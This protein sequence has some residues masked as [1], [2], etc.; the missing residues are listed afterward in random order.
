MG[1]LRSFRR[2]LNEKNVWVANEVQRKKVEL[3]K[4]FVE[5]KVKT[6]ADFARDVLA[7]VG[8]N[9]PADIKKSAEETI[10]RQVNAVVNLNQ[11]Q[12]LVKD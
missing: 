5:D 2:K 10:A 11:E 9:L 3:A 6:D 4:K 7:A 1:N 8:E 12:A